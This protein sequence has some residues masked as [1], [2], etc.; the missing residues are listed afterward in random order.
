MRLRTWIPT[1]G[2]VLA[3]TL[4]LGAA[5]LLLPAGGEQGPADLGGAAHGPRAHAETALRAEGPISAR[6]P[7]LAGSRARAGGV[8]H[9]TRAGA[10]ASRVAGRAPDPLL[11]R[12]AHALAGDEPGGRLEAIEA[13]AEVGGGGARIL[14][15]RAAADPGTPDEEREALKHALARTRGSKR[16]PLAGLQDHADPR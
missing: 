15:A 2:P 16:N 6:E 14:L 1:S 10:P 5:A 7:R 11:D 3:V 8:E 12:W 4:G 9:P 13:L